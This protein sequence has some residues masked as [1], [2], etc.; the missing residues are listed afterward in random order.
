MRRVGEELG[1]CYV[2]LVKACTAMNVPRPVSGQWESLRLG[3]A[4][5][6]VP[7]PEAQAGVAVEFLLRPKGTVSEGEL[8]PL[9]EAPQAEEAEAVRAEAGAQVVETVAEPVRN[10]GAVV[11]TRQELYEKVWQMNL[12][13]LANEWGT[14]YVQLVAACD[15][16]NVPR[17]PSGHWVRLSLGLPVGKFELPEAGPGTPTEVTLGPQLLRVQRAARAAEWRRGEA[18]TAEDSEPSGVKPQVPKRAANVQPAGKRVEPGVE[19]P[20]EGVSL[21]PIADRHMK[22]LQEAKPGE[23]GFVSVSGPDLFWC[24]MTLA[25]VPRFG[26][27]LH[28]LICELEHRSYSF[29]EGEDDGEGLGIVR[30]GDRVEVRWS[31]GKIDLEREPTNV[32]KRRPSWTWSLKETKATGELAVEVNASGLKGRRKWKEGDGRSLEEILGVV[33]EKV[34]ATFGWFKEQRK[35]EAEL[36]RQ[37]EEAEK[38]RLEEA[39]REAERQAKLEEERK[40]RERVRRHE[41]KLEQIAELRRQNLLVA[42]K[43]WIQS[44]GVAAYVAYCEATWRVTAGGALTQAQADWLA[45]AKAEVAR[46]GPFGKGYPVP[47]KDG[48]LDVSTLPVGGPYPEPTELEELEEVEPDQPTAQPEVRYVEVPRQPEQFPFWLL[49]RKY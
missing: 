44:H 25:L 29:E 32:D 13:R 4:V 31:E 43:L 35:R 10:R 11:V 40:A 45:W 19:L 49:H 34:E 12:K 6:Q 26:R 38:R 17:P 46:M 22:S 9:P 18:T 28:A 30:D 37:Q 8:P 23:L 48:Q 14:S 21:H 27:A 1:T 15:V 33:V 7:L 16:M 47:E 36:A 42:A 41:A 20:P 2:E 5:D 3:Q 24:D 39:T